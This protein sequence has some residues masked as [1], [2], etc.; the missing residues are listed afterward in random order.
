MASEIFE[1]DD[2]IYMSEAFYT[3]LCIDV[4]N[5][6]EILHE[7][8]L[9]NLNT[10]S[11]RCT[12]LSLGVQQNSVVDS[13]GVQQNFIVDNIFP[14]NKKGN[15][16]VRGIIIVIPASRINDYMNNNNEINLNLNIM[17]KGFKPL[18]DDFKNG[19]IY[20]ESLGHCYFTWDK[21]QNICGIWD[22]CLHKPTGKG[23]GSKLMEAI[24]DVLS[25]NLPD[26][27]ILWLGVDMRNKNF[28]AVVSLYAKFGFKSP[29]ISHTDPFG[30]NWIETL[31]YGFI[32]MRRDNDYIDPLDINRENVLTHIK[33]IRRNF[34]TINN[35]SNNIIDIDNDDTFM[36][37]KRLSC[38]L[39][40]RFNKSF[41]KWLKRLSLASSS[42]NKDGTVTQKEISSSFFL[43]NPKEN[44]NGEII[45]EI[46]RDK[47]GE[48][49]FGEE[50][51]VNIKQARYN[52]HTHPREAYLS[53]NVKIGF[54][55]GTDYSSILMMS[56]YNEIKTIF[57]CVITIEGIYTI[58]IAEFWI[59]NFTKLQKI[60]RDI[61]VQKIQDIIKNEFNIKKEF[62]NNINTEQ[63]GK[64]YSDYTNNK[65]II[66]DKNGD[67][68]PI[69]HVS[70][71]TWDDII[72][73]QVISIYYPSLY[74][75]CFIKHKRIKEFENLQGIQ[76]HNDYEL[77]PPYN[78]E[79]EDNEDD[80]DDDE[81]QP[82]DDE[83][84][85]ND[86]EDEDNEDDE[87]DDELQPY[88]DE[89]S[90]NDDW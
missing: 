69:F 50:E 6:F 14:N 82:Y 37:D 21:K 80:E 9:Q 79:D 2:D 3:G 75:Q 90:D 89:L 11:K 29:L 85:D 35:I 55:S 77:L 83:L 88:D 16:T 26:D 10:F 61:G 45:W 28:Y 60:I 27:T 5:N 41:A 71:N 30:N 66:H 56:L 1:N 32:S 81:L 24:L 46:I 43:D 17:N 74:S 59:D 65:K 39:N 25:A 19:K 22:V 62:P 78:D 76:Q 18:S 53:H 4:K 58:S 13:L 38:N 52:F 47:K 31:P 57:H 64:I 44:F 40:M 49:T 51:G 48:K 86:D 7:F 15:E 68:Y 67:S 87:D 8:K 42:L 63:A 72:N 84:S 34:I 54:P 12:E 23:L 70:F 36:D 73:G 20:N 33:Y